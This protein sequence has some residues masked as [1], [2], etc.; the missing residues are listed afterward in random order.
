MYENKDTHIS[1]KDFRDL[2]PVTSRVIRSIEKVMD[3]DDPDRVAIKKACDWKDCYTNEGKPWYYRA[4]RQ[5]SGF[6]K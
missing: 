3:Q 2:S 6:V 5:R 1:H 4:G